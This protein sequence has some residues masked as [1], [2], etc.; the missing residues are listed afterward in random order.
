VY[1]DLYL[2]TI[3][4]ASIQFAPDQKAV[5]ELTP[6]Q[7]SD[8]LDAGDAISLI[9]ATTVHAIAALPLPLSTIHVT[10]IVVNC[11]EQS[12]PHIATIATAVNPKERIFRVDGLNQK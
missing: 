4:M 8:I 2:Q 12:S 10:S 11:M 7:R 5:D 3:T 1:F 9:I 6:K